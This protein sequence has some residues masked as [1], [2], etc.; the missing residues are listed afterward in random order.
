M[1]NCLE[2]LQSQIPIFESAGNYLLQ[3]KCVWVGVGGAKGA[4]GLQLDLQSFLS[5]SYFCYMQN[6]NDDT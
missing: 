4:P 6:K 2:S 5:E 1:K 3:S